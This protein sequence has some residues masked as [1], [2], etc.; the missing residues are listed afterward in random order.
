MAH[1]KKKEQIK[2]DTEIQVKILRYDPT[3]STESYWQE[4]KILLQNG[5]SISILSILQ[6]IFENQDHSLAFT[7]PCEKGLCGMCTLVVNGKT[8]L[9]CT[10]FLSSNVTIEPIKGF[11]VIRDLVVDRNRKALK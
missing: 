9:A 7:G 6:S 11:N 3:S 8:Q 5:E 10:T 1:Q 4:Y 2:K